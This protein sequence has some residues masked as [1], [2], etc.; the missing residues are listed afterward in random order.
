MKKI[1]LLL[2]MCFGFSACDNTSSSDATKDRARA[3]RGAETDI[4]NE[5]LAKKSKMME[6]DLKRR[7]RFFSGVENHYEGKFLIGKDQ[8]QLKMTLV[9]TLRIVNS[10]RV[11][12]LEEIQDDLN[13]LA[14][15]VQTA[16]WYVK[17]NVGISGCVFEK[18]KPDLATGVLHLASETCP[19]RFIVTLTTLSTKSEDRL[20]TSAILARDLLNGNTDFADYLHVEASSK[21][22]P[23]GWNALIK[24]TK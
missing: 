22:N 17:D 14:F 10:D 7:Y 3:E 11:R 1:T 19:N 8:Y 5:N 21:Y 6:E 23:Q 9:P 24:R 2:I 20:N 15:T 12:T 13:N 18:S 16:T 4:E